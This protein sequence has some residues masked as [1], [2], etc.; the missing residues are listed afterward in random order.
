MRRSV[1][2]R[3]FESIAHW[4]EDHLGIQHAGWVLFLPAIIVFGLLLWEID[5]LET[6]RRGESA[7]SSIRRHM[8]ES[9][10]TR[11]AD[12][13]EI[14]TNC[15]ELVARHDPLCRWSKDAQA[16]YECVRKSEDPSWEPAPTP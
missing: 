14:T 12:D 1:E 13:F 4:L 2:S 16:Y 10:L 8:K 5:F 7:D 15:H 9:F 6:L 11:C 3:L